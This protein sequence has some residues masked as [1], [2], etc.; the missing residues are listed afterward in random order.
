MVIKAEKSGK[1]LIE[2]RGVNVSDILLNESIEQI[3]EKKIIQGNL[4]KSGVDTAAYNLAIKGVEFVTV[5]LN[6]SGEEE[7]GSG[8]IATFGLA[9]LGI[10]LFLFLTLT[11]GQTLVRSLVEEKSNLSL[12]HISEPTRPY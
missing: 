8:F 5:K 3:I 12:I 2:F 9:Y 4:I 1:Q 11:T 6:S 7:R 10:F